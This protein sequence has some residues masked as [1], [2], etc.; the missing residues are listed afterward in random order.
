MRAR[1]R[2]RE[3]RER[4]KRD[5]AV[6]SRHTAGVSE[7]FSGPRDAGDAAQGSRCPAKSAIFCPPTPPAPPRSAR[8]YSEQQP[9]PRVKGEVE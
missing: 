6:Y 5:A 4:E 1:A 8:Q 3:E 2:E 9:P 7:L